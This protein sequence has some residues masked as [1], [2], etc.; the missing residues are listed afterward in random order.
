MVSRLAVVNDKF[1]D[2]MMFLMGFNP[3]GC[4]RLGMVDYTETG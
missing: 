4:S 3:V 1:S 2:G